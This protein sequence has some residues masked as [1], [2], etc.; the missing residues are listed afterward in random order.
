MNHNLYTMNVSSFI[1]TILL[2]LFSVSCLAD[3]Y[4]STSL[5]V[6]CLSDLSALE[7]DLSYSLYHE[8][9][10]DLEGIIYRKVKEWVAKDPTLAPSLLRLHYHDCVVR[11]CDA[12]ILLDHEGSEKTSNMSKSLRGFEVIDDIK[13]E[14]EKKCPK[15]VSC[16]DILTTVAR[17]A[18]VLASGPYWTIPY[19]RKDGRVSLAKEAMIVP[20]GSESVTSLIEFF[21]SKGL[22]VLDLVVLSGAHTI[23]KT[24]CESV[25]HRLYDYKGTKKPDP[26]LDPKYLNYLRRKC[27]WASENVN[28]DGET[29]NTFD[30][31]YYQNL[32]KNMGLLS[33]DQFLYHDSRTKPVANG[34][35]FEPTLF[36]NQFGVSMVKLSSILDLSSQDDGEIRV[37]CKY[38]NKY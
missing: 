10:P 4:S 32:K 12:S 16:A 5:K 30:T 20:K 15:T 11:G 2:I 23:G 25:Q 1:I 17:D 22:N 19:G 36:K 29:P 13:A 21:Q 18:T 26:S 9:C 6:P 35:S 8:S 34:L 7:D 27:R 31:Q 28:L 37:D 14:I 24:T 38:V 3:D 33:T